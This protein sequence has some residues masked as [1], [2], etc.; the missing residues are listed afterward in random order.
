MNNLAS[1]EI[2]TPLMTRKKGKGVSMT[3][4]LDPEAIS[5]TNGSPMPSSGSV[6]TGPHHLDSLT[7]AASQGM[8]RM[9]TANRSPSTAGANPLAAHSQQVQVP[10]SESSQAFRDDLRK[11][12][13]TMQKETVDNVTQAFSSSHQEGE[14]DPD[15]VSIE[16][17]ESECRTI[18][19]DIDAASSVRKSG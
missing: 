1:C 17:K 10:P 8:K 5:P 4:E 16:D 2:V 9:P 19:W 6:L 7:P 13:D 11:V 3:K 12:Q 14:N 18:F 15:T